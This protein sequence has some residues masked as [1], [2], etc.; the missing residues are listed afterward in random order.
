MSNKNI[1]V[2]TELL[3]F[4]R[5]IMIRIQ[6]LWFSV[7]A[8]KFMIFLSVYVSF[9]LAFLPF[10]REKENPIVSSELKKKFCKKI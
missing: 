3:E 1:L 6:V 4:W 8:K 2:Q 5:E 9:G 7:K 10:L